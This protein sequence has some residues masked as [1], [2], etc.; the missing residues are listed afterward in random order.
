VFIIKELVEEER[1]KKLKAKFQSWE[2]YGKKEQK[3]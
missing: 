2:D 1:Q 3:V